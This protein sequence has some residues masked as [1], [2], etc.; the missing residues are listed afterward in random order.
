MPGEPAP[1][2]PGSGK[3]RRW[4]TWLVIPVAIGAPTGFAVGLIVDVIERFLLETVIL[5]LP[6]AWFA[7][8]GTAVFLLTRLALVKVAGATSPGTAEL[9]PIFF[10]DGSRPYPLRQV[11]GRLL[12]GA[13][14]VG[15]GGSQ[16]LESQSV[17]VGG[18]TGILLRRWLSRRVPELRTPA[19]RQLVLTC[20]AAAG[21]A[22]V[23]SSPLLGAAYGIEMPFRNMI[24]W[25]RAVPSAVAA[26][27]SFGTA[28]LIKS[29]RG[30]MT[31]VS[32]PLTLAELLGV[33]AVAVACGLGAR[34]FAVTA[35]R[36]RHWKDG[37][38][39]WLRA[40]AAGVALAALAGLA[41]Y[42]TG[43]AITAGPGYVASRWAIEPG[44]A[45]TQT[46]GLLAIALV[47]RTT[48]VL[49]CVAGGGGGGVFTSMATNGLLIGC[50]IGALLGLPDVTL[51]A[52]VGAGTF[53]G[54]GYRI[55]LAGF[56]MIVWSSAE[57]IPSVLGLAAIAIGFVLMGQESASEAQ[58]DPVPTGAPEDT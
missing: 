12:S 40:A 3:P 49:L 2:Q 1:D 57:L 33:L 52:L 28:A 30:L 23:F 29:S 46:A 48:T 35:L 19:G 42:L 7:V 55:P 6:G 16:G 53:L 37:S 22:T 43:A 27:A 10:H 18:S 20:G 34:A 56:S 17:T 41:W 54:V 47:L 45:I 11:P 25:R 39:P 14:T 24:D 51:L 13:A 31:Y 36:I 38:R 15:L 50:L 8:F 4:L 5:G 9:F 58:L 21:I 44:S 32:H 26:T